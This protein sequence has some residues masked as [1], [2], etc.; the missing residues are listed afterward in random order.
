MSAQ[1]D[2][3]DD[4]AEVELETAS[5]CGK[6][7]AENE[8][9]V[10]TWRGERGEAALVVSDGMGGHER[11]REA[12]AIVVETCV[13]TFDEADGE[14]PDRLLRRALTAAHGAV[15]RAAEAYETNGMG[16]TAVVALVEA[17]GTSP[18]LHL[19]HVGDSRAYLYRGRSLYRLTA[20]HSVVAQLVRD[21]HLD[22]TAAWR[23][24]DRNV[25]QR[26]IGQRQALEPEVGT[27]RK[28]A[29]GDLI[30][31]CSDGLHD[32]LPEREIAR[33]L[34][35]SPSP[36]EACRNLLE[37]AFAQDEA[38]DDISV[39]CLRLPEIARKRRAT[40]PDGPTE[41]TPPAG[42]A[43]DDERRRG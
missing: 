28:L 11:G 25:I 23:H 30:L 36:A 19:A 33:I 8:D 34:G 35:L 4:L 16:A 29:P 17:A 12:A 41:E 3:R 10:A 13:A 32:A 42:P 1:N 39:A 2:R 20:D 43:N 27:P 37:T 40:R 18:R 9:A 7:H 15:Q 22:E 38:E 21:G 24:P 14:P 5:R 6:A 26:A 31:L